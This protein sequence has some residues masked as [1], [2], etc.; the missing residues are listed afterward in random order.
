MNTPLT[1][2]FRRIKNIIFIFLF[3]FSLS[4]AKAQVINIPEAQTGILQVS[5]SESEREDYNASLKVPCN[6]P[7]WNVWLGLTDDWNDG[8]NWCAGIPTSSTDVLIPGTGGAGYF[9]PVIKS[10][11]IAQTKKLIIE[12]DTLEINAP[13]AGSLS[14][15]DSLFIKSNSLVTVAADS[16]MLGNGLFMNTNFLPF[17]G[18]FHEQKMQL[19]FKTS[20]FL[21]M[22]I[23]DGDVIDKICFPIRIRRSTSPFPVTINMYYATNNATY[24]TFVNTGFTPIPAAPQ[25]CLA[26]QQTIPVMVFAGNVDLSAI[27]LNGSGTHVI[28]LPF[29]FTF[30]TAGNY[31]LIV[32]ICYS[33]NG[34]SLNDDTWQTQTTG[35]KSVLLLAN[36]GAYSPP[37]CAWSNTAPN[38]TALTQKLTSDYRPNICFE[39]QQPY[40][41]YPINIKGNWKNNGDFI[42]GKSIVTFNKTTI[43]YI[44]GATSTSFYDLT[45]DNAA[46]IK[47]F[48]S[49]IVAHVLDLK[50]GKLNLNSYSV[51]VLNPGTGGIVRT[52]GG[53]QSE[54]VPPGYGTI[55]WAIGSTTG[56]HVFPFQTSGGTYIP[57]T[58]NLTTGDIGTVKAATYPT[59]VSNLPFPAGV[60]NVNDTN[61]ANNSAFTVD[62]F[63]HIQNTGPSGKAKI[64]FTYQNSEAPAPIV[65]GNIRA[66]CYVFTNN[67]WKI[68]PYNMTNPVNLPSPLTSQ[69]IAMGVTG[70]NL[71]ANVW[72]L[73]DASS[74]L[75]MS[76]SNP[77]EMQVAP[78]PFTD[79]I[80][81]S[82]GFIPGNN[83]NISLTLFTLLGELAAK[84]TI[85]TNMLSD[86]Q[87]FEW[88]PGN[89]KNG[90]YFLVIMTKDEIRTERIVKM[91][92]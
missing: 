22:G 38:G 71:N 89:I 2:S 36:L 68:L 42:S 5:S 9:H 91:G 18:N 77:S 79:K 84:T 60:T 10:G 41:R 64:K 16:A 61:N 51:S 14:I 46:G 8:N 35:Y 32:E 40:D 28:S 88:S 26:P 57:L 90:I 12:N 65:N 45:I 39:F 17:R 6:P 83:E 20:E 33:T 11:V 58:Y 55:E 30:N 86:N 54:I 74:P 19:M 23:H 67:K 47:L 63:W 87:Q 78:N 50:S 43:Q 37:A 1:N 62:R 7:D 53:I 81:F 34:S 3:L 85:S 73:A 66:Q 70:N 69:V 31:P 80:I 92:N 56:A 29:P 72:A 75:R 13:N 82:L 27:P 44:S 21:A 25:N 48:S 24:P 52:A 76:H 59:A 4:I 15:E 49:P